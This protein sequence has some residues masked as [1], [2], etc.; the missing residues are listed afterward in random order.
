MHTA[1]L[2]LLFS[3]FRSDAACSQISRHSEFLQLA[4]VYYKNGQFR[5]SEECFVSALQTSLPEDDEE[6]AS[7]LRRLGDVYISLDE[8]GRAERSYSESLELYKRR[9]DRLNTVILM[10]SL[11]IAYAI[12]HRESDAMKTL[13]RALSIAQELQ[14]S[15]ADLISRL[16]NDLGIA[17]HRAGRLKEA[18][19][20]FAGAADMI[21][22]A[23]LPMD[24]ESL[25]T[26]GAV[27]IVE[28]QYAKAEDLLNQAL[29]LRLAALGPFHPDLSMTLALL[30]DLY[31]RS[32]RYDQAEQRYRE[33]L[34]LLEARP[35]EFDTRI[36]RLLY[37]LALTCEAAGQD[38][39]ADSALAQAAAIALKNLNK[40]DMAAIIEE[41]SSR[42]EKQGES[43]HAADLRTAVKRSRAANALVIDAYNDSKHH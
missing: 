42:L 18:E 2:V 20:H 15:R 12:E 23:G 29:N 33:G 38:R 40:H 17:Y 14:G 6:R 24:E 8:F 32:R 30:G 27:L 41:Y 35:L 39:E 22:A 28:G 21:S 13:K 26:R 36:A 4:R 16:L 9:A 11:G 34:Q 43:K 5:N 3:V 19:K 31:L 10:R 25:T 7:I 1:Y 37:S